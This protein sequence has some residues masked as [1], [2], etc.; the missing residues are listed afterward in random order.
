MGVFQME[1]ERKGCCHALRHAMLELCVGRNVGYIVG[2]E[3]LRI[4]GFT[5]GLNV[6]VIVG[7]KVE[8][9]VGFKDGV[10]VVGFKDGINVLTVVGLHVGFRLR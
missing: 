5:L 4:V 9:M 7:L 2:Y 10:T 3:V 1:V 8:V 6:G